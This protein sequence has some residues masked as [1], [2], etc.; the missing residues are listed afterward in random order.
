MPA[1]IGL[2]PFLTAEGNFAFLSAFGSAAT[3]EKFTGRSNGSRKL[4]Q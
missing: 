2:R 3:M 4:K 1:L